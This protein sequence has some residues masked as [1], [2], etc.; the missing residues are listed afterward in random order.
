[1]AKAKKGEDPQA[2]PFVGDITDYLE[3]GAPEAIRKAIGRAGKDDILAPNFPYDR[4]MKRKDYEAQMKVLQVQLV[5]MLHDLLRTGKRLCVLFEGR[6]A[7]GKGGAIERM[8]ENLN[9][10]SAYI[11]ALP[12]PTEREATQW[13]FQRYVDW[14][15][16]AGEIA[17]FDRSWYN[18][19]VVEKVFGFCTDDQRK[20]FFRQ[21]PEFE[22]MLVDEGITLV[23]LWLNVDRGEQLRR[24]LARER[25]PLKQWKLSWIDVEGLKK[26]D[27][28]SRAIRETLDKSHTAFAPWTVI[29]ADDK[30]R[31]RIAAIQTVLHAVDF[32][33]RDLGAIGMIDG[34]ICGGPDRLDS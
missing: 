14:L 29:R 27:D 20:L 11:V 3:H 18:R 8:R 23:K 15:P 6:D 26:W 33:G 12:K 4:E 22:R 32:A 1:M 21:L 19:G 24:F 7:A 25:D 34:A 2:I 13:Y 28:Y 5:R 30:K 17:L 9:P 10:R 16:A 31:A